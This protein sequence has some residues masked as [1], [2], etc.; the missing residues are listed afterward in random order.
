MG[1]SIAMATEARG[2]KE[3]KKDNQDE[4]TQSEK[5]RVPG[6]AP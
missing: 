2:V 3:I 4:R 1:P 5:E 6:T